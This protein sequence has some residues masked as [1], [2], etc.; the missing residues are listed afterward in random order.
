MNDE[1]NSGEER[2]AFPVSPREVAA[3]LVIGFLLVQGYLLIRDRD[4]TSAIDRHTP[5]AQPALPL[6]F[7]R[8]MAYDPLSFLGRGRQA[9][10]WD[11]TPEGLVLTDAGR[12]FFEASGDRFASRASAGRRRVARISDI[13][14]RDGQRE[15]FFFYE[16]T[17]I[18][19]PAAALLYPAPQTGGEYYGRA[20]LEQD[21][22]EWKVTSFETR[23]FDE[24]LARLRDIAAGVRR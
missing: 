5:F 8:K 7:S 21:Q 19:P 10:L 3:V 9:G 11:W 6:E 16:W 15:I 12:S 13:V 20:V 24:P 17:E 18:T 4:L 22:G 1:A 2:R 14:A 23:D